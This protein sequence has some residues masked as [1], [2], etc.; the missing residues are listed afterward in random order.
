MGRVCDRGMNAPIRL[1]VLISGGGRT[2]QNLIDR[3]A[4]GSLPARI[5][6]V[7][8][9]R[10]NVAGLERAKRH[11][12][13]IRVV[14]R[15]KFA[16]AKGFSR[17][18]TEALESFSF[19][20]ITLAGFMSLYLFPDKWAGKMINIHPGLLPEFGGKGL[21]GERVHQAVLKAGVRESG[22]TVHFA[23]HVYDHGPVILERRVPVT[24]EDTAVTLAARVF[25]AECEAYPEAIRRIAS[26]EV[27]MEALRRA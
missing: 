17:G 10:G 9:S 5:E 11:G 8:S 21:Y 19:D 18:V 22:C 25:E 2:L 23:D 26:G 24:P 12:I 3:I 20:L 13:P 27:R 1:A 16:D 14:E 6:V 4:E 15:R 7:L